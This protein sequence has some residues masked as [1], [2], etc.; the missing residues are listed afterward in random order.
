MSK[1]NGFSDKKNGF[2]STIVKNRRPEIRF[3]S[4]MRTVLYD[5][6]WFRK[7]KKPEKIGVYAVYRGIKKQK[8][9]QYDITV[10]PSQMLGDEFP[11]T[12][13]HSHIQ[14]NSELVRVLKGKALCLLQKG[15]NKTIEDVYTVVLKKDESILIPSDYE[16][17]IIN[18]SKGTLVFSNWISDKTKNDY[19]VFEHHQGACYYYIRKG[20]IKNK[21]YE[22]VP[23][24]KFQKSERSMPKKIG[25]FKL[26]LTN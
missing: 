11:K 9:L 21:N 1:E 10:M 16:H 26:T 25:F 2:L 14:K 17:L 22:K 23:K 24:L 15:K 3:L 6:N 5:Q 12:K 7:I 19:S 8:G 18:P 4:E 13:G 20:W